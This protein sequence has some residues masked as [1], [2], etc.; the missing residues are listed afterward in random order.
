[1]KTG[2]PRGTRRF[3]QVPGEALAVDPAETA[4]RQQASE[5]MLE[6]LM[7]EHPERAT[8]SHPHGTRSP[9]RMPM[10][11]TSGGSVQAIDF[12]G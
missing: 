10:P 6:L 2:M 11:P 5:V 7:R 3:K 4:A 1:M 8:V 12:E 9:R